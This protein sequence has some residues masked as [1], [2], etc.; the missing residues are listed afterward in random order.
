MSKKLYE[1]LRFRK[2]EQ[3]LSFKISVTAWSWEI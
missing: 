3:F 1:H 2:M